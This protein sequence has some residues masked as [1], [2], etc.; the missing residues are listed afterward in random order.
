MPLGF[1][2]PPA[3]RSEAAVNLAEVARHV[4]KPG[5][6]NCLV[7]HAA[8][9]GGINVKH[10]DIDMSLVDPSSEVDVHMGVD[11]LDFTCQQCHVTEKHRIK[12]NAM[13]VSPGG[14]TRVACADC[15]GEKAHRKVKAGVGYGAEGA[16]R[17]LEQLNRHAERI[18]C[19]TCHIPAFA[20]YTETKMHWDWSTT[21][22]GDMEETPDELS[23]AAVQRLTFDPKKGSFVYQEQTVPVYRWYNYSAGRYLLGEKIDPDSTTLLAYPLGD[24]NDPKAKIYPFKLHT[25]KQPYDVE[26]RVLITPKT[27]GLPGDEDAYWVAGDWEKSSRAG[28]QASDLDFGGE[29]GFA[30]TAMYWRITHSVAPAADALSCPECHRRTGRLDWQALGYAG[31]PMEQATERSD[32]DAGSTADVE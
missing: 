4:G 5:R 18:A 21:E 23:A 17:M 24:R 6:K 14:E 20:R 32:S 26:Q 9:G 12:G 2:E 11:G 7:C 13:S 25:G 8:G 16:K 27:Y 10:G 29:V 30:P 15:H 31:D 1:E 19:Q 28:M 22:Y 3:K